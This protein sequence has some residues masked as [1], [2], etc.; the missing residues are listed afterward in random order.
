LEFHA[1]FQAGVVGMFVLQKQESDAAG[2][3]ILE[4]RG[5]EKRP[6]TKIYRGGTCRV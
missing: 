3:V 4:S 5:G 6:S 1:G 2:E